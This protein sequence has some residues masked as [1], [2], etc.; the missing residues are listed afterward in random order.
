MLR[1][2]AFLGRSSLFL[3]IF[4]TRFEQ[5]IVQYFC[6]TCWLDTC[7]LLLI[8]YVSRMYFV[9]LKRCKAGQSNEATLF[10]DVVYLRETEL[11]SA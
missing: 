6:F 10:M 11:K 5:D 8:S 7:F 9:I 3:E 1:A 2:F 4:H